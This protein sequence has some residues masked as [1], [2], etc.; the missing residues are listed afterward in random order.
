MKNYS[1]WMRRLRWRGHARRLVAALLQAG[2]LTPIDARTHRHGRGPFV[3][4]CV[5]AAGHEFHDEDPRVVPI[6]AMVAVAAAVANPD[7]LRSLLDGQCACVNSSCQWNNFAG[8]ALHVFE[9]MG[10]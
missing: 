10:L 2:V 8:T 5:I 6:P 3:R 4:N 9:R 1:T 7:C